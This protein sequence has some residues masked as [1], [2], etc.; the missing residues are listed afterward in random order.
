[1]HQPQQAYRGGETALSMSTPQERARWALDDAVDRW[2]EAHHPDLVVGVDH[3]G[4][5]TRTRFEPLGMAKAILEVAARERGRARETVKKAR[6]AGRTWRDVA[7]ALGLER[8]E[9]AWEFAAGE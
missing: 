5:I 1:M 9:D 8:I 2:V 4:F 6:G 7:D 3:D